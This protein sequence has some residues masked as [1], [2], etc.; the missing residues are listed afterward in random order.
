MPPRPSTK[1]K[2]R[3]WRPYSLTAHHKVAKCLA[4]SL[5]ARLQNPLFKLSVVDHLARGSRKAVVKCDV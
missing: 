1:G 5:V 2:G 3:G 4:I